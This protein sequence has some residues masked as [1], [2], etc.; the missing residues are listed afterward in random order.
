MIT[1]KEFTSQNLKVIFWEASIVRA[2]K[3]PSLQ[4]KTLSETAGKELHGSFAL[5][6][7]YTCLTKLLALRNVSNDEKH[8]LR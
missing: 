2:I 6:S 3:L 4:L 7:H 5:N 8:V 1:S